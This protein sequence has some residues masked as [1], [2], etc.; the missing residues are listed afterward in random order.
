MNAR[1]NEKIKNELNVFAPHHLIF[2]ENFT[3][4]CKKKNSSHRN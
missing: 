4:N 1:T 3:I 2:C